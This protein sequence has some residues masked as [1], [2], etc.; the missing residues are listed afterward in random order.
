MS[1]ELANTFCTSSVM[2]RLNGKVVLPRLCL[3]NVSSFSLYSKL[4]E[5]VTG[6]VCVDV[7]SSVTVDCKDAH[8]YLE[9]YKLRETL[10]KLPNLTYLPQIILKKRGACL[11]MR[12]GCPEMIFS[13]EYWLDE[14]RLASATV[15]RYSTD[16]ILLTSSEPSVG[17]QTSVRRSWTASGERRQKEQGT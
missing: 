5:Q 6:K 2:T 16:A 11:L 10:R 7:Q 1:R 17:R 9:M 15:P 13:H 14:G 4:A 12:Q 8:A 3:G